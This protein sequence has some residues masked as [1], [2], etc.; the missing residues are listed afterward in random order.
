MVSG[1]REVTPQSNM[2]RKTIK[3]ANKPLPS[4][5]TVGGSTPTQPA[6]SASPVKRPAAR[7]AK[8][9]S[10]TEVPAVVPS[11]ETKPLPTLE[12]EHSSA[13]V[14]QPRMTRDTQSGSGDVSHKATF[15]F[16]EPHAAQVFLSGEFN[17]WS[18]NATPMERKPDG[19]WEA[20]LA[21]QP[22]RYQ[23]KYIADGQWLPDPEAR[24]YVPNEYGSVNSVI[25]V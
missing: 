24:E 3:Q 5:L 21:L 1:R 22:G 18:P 19:H 2:A 14:E 13:A 7:K 17:G 4:A 15:V 8:A 11:Q 20:S 12:R 9:A 16:C 23:Y 10:G 6:A 25:V